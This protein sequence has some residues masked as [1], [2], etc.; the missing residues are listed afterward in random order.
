MIPVTGNFSADN[1]LAEGLF[2]TKNALKFV[3]EGSEH[4][5]QGAQT[6]VHAAFGH[7]NRKVILYYL[8]EYA[9]S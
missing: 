4:L 7:K 6:R 2:L 5:L 1:S 8:N 3:R 9:Y